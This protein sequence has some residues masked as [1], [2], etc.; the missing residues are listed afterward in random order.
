MVIIQQYTPMNPASDNTP[1][2]DVHIEYPSRGTE[3]KDTIQLY[4]FIR[5][6]TR[7]PFFAGHVPYKMHFNNSVA[8][9][10]G[11]SPNIGRIADQEVMDALRNNDIITN[12]EYFQL[13][14]LLS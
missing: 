10:L 4:I 13:M 12:E 3:S 8:T 5:T 7:E 1:G 2:W 9:H 6:N 14:L 11:L